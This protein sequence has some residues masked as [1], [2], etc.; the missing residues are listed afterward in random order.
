[1]AQVCVDP[2]GARPRE[3]GSVM[4]A[5]E[6]HAR[7]GATWPAVLAQLGV[8]EAALRNRHGPCPAC[9]GKDRFR[10]DNKRG[11]G[12]YI[13]G[14]CGA[15]DGFRLL[16]RVHGWPFAEA[17][18]RVIEVAG[19][20]GGISVAWTAP[21]PR[22]Q[23][24]ETIATPT[25]RVVRL[26]R[27]CCA[28]ADCADIV[29]Y[30]E[31]RGLWPLP[32][33]CTLRAHASVE[34]FEDG[35]RIGRWPA[36]VADVVDAAGELVTLHVTYLESGQKLSGHEPRKML[37]PLTGRH[38]CAVRL[39]APGEVLGIAE[40]IETALSAALVEGTPVWAA[41]NTSLLSRF[42]PPPAVTTLRLYADRDEAG[43]TAA[44]RLMERLQGRV[45]LEVRVPPAPAKDWNDVLAIRSAAHAAK[46][47]IH[48]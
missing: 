45:R 27:G 22:A 46:G 15:G 5:A 20:S 3:K 39:M 42:E 2:M 33:G 43:L 16:E 32:D 6:I 10:F 1:M 25:E 41:L 26:R 30:L 29:S 12:D 34:Y 37:T 48:D 9:G 4:Q 31:S 28:V 8:P 47:S 44:C 13:C 17:R 24:R 23:P 40:G 35:R 14:Q 21:A 38:G 7:L 11:R 19:L 36:I 18:R